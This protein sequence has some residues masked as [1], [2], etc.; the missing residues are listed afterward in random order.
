MPGQD[1]ASLTGLTYPCSGGLVVLEHE[2][3][4][5]QNHVPI[6]TSGGPVLDNFPAGQIEHFAQGIVI[7]KAGL[8]LGNLAELAV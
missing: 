7:G 2:L 4:L 8:V 1:S 3:E 6:S 5:S